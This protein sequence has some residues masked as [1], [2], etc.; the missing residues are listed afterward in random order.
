MPL[1]ASHPLE[2]GCWGGRLQVAAEMLSADLSAVLNPVVTC[3]VRRFRIF[4]S[5]PQEAIGVAPLR[6]TFTCVRV[7]MHVCGV[8]VWVWYRVCVRVSSVVLI[9]RFHILFHALRVIIF[10]LVVRLFFLASWFVIPII[11]VI[12]PV[13]WVSWMNLSV[14]P[15]G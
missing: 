15:F 12:F 11:T 5:H 1:R 9:R 4:A 2:A 7:C 10:I 6:W 8:A 14:S 13:Q 3:G